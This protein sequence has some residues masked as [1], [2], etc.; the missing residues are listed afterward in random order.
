MVVYGVES[1]LGT[2]YVG[3][4]G[5]YLQRVWT[6]GQAPGSV[7]AAAVSPGAAASPGWVDHLLDDLRR[8]LSGEPL[9]LNSWESKFDLSQ[10]TPF[11]QRV[12]RAL[13]EVR[14]GQTCTYGDLA[15][16]VQSPRAARAIGGAMASN[17][18]PLFVPCHRVVATTGLGGYGGGLSLKRRLLELE[19]ALT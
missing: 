13:L 5:G 12:Y 10:A 16:R 1:D 9:D 15:R 7:Q 17:P 2:V 14:R 6:P 19:G 4:D 11:R 18:I 8:Y 3:I